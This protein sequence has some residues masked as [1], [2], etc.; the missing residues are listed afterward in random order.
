MTAYSTHAT[1]GLKEDVS[2]IISNIAPTATPFQSMIG[3]KKV[4]Q[5]LF[6]W[7]EDDLASAGANA[8][9][10]GADAPAVSTTPTVMRDNV[11]QIL[12]K[13]ARVSGTNEASAAYGRK[14]E[15]AYQLELRGKELKR[16]LEFIYLN[17]QAQN[18]AS[19]GVARTT[20]SAQAQIDAGNV[21][22]AAASGGL[23][24]ADLIE[25]GDI[26]FTEGSEPTVMMYHNSFAG[27]VASWAEADGTRTKF[28]DAKG[29]EFAHQLT[30]YIDPVGNNIR[31]VPN[32]FIKSTDALV[33]A[34]E[35]F[36]SA[37]LRPTFKQ[38]LAKTGDAEKHQ[39]VREVGLLHKNYKSSAVISGI[40]A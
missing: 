5:P 35:M 2:D 38:E 17:A 32:R 9:A 21:I 22:T 12:T 40:T 14:S 13:V 39:L 36:Q 24:E 8:A 6:Q 4:S 25:A 19:E 29:T 20:A 15:L 30:V 27:S 37:D 33:F 3:S 34:P 7:Q 1:V 28:V 18:N 16:D 11:T 23:A 31:L 10:E 26:L